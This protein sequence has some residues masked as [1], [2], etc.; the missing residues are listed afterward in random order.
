MKKEGSGNGKRKINFK[1]EP[2]HRKQVNSYVVLQYL[3]KNSDENN[4]VTT[5][6][7]IAFFE[8]C[9]INAERRSIYRDIEDVK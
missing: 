9:G 2:K 3:L 7:I 4:V 6:D 8:K 5:Y 1:E